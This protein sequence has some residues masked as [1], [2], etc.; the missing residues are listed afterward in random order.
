MMDRLTYWKTKL[1]V[2]KA[3]ERLGFA[4]KYSNRDALVRN[5]E[6]YLAN[7]D[8]LDSAT[9]LTHRLPWAQ[10]ALRLAKQFF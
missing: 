3:E 5:Y 2:A 9:G 4:P 8:R 1:K 7:A 6:W 10:G